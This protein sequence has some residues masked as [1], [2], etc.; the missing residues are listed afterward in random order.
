[1]SDICDDRV[2]IADL[3][4]EILASL[5]ASRAAEAAK[6]SRKRAARRSIFEV[7]EFADIV[8]RI[9]EI[10]SRAEITPR[11]PLSGLPPDLISRID[12]DWYL[13]RED[14]CKVR[15]A[16]RW[17]RDVSTAPP[18]SQAGIDALED[19]LSGDPHSEITR[20][21]K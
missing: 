4:Q 15:V 13:S 12:L 10:S 14:A 3:A 16:I 20:R 11:H 21:K 19:N 1:M 2:I 18:L 5:C 8:D 9:R 17:I 6:K 7:L